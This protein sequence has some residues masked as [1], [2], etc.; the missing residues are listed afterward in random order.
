MISTHFTQPMD[1]DGNYIDGP[2]AGYKFKEELGYTTGRHTGVDYNGPGSGNA[3]LGMEIRSIGDGVVRYTGD[4]TSIGFGNTVIIEHQLSD[5]LK[6]E[7]GCDSLFSRYMHLNTIDVTAGDAVTIGQRIGSC[8]NTGTQWAHLH[9]DVYKSTIEGGGVHFRYDKNTQLM[10]YLDS[11]IFIESHNTPPELLST[12]GMLKTDGET[13]LRSEPRVAPETLSKWLPADYGYVDCTGFEWGEEIDGNTLWV[14]TISG[15]YIHSS[16]FSMLPTAFSFP[17]INITQSAIYPQ[18]TTDKFV[19]I[20][21]N[22][23]NPM[24]TP[25]PNVVIASN[26]QI[27]YSE[28]ADALRMMIDAAAQDKVI[29]NPQSGYRSFDTQKAIYES[30][31]AKDGKTKADTYSARPGYSEHQ[32]G[33]AMDFTPIEDSFKDTAAYMWLKNN[34]HKFGFVERF[35]LGKE[36]ITGYIYEPWHWRYVGVKDAEEI[37]KLSKTL[38]EYYNVKGG[39]YE[40]SYEVPDNQK[41]SDID[42]ENNSLLKQILAI[43]Q[44]L[45]N[46]FKSIFK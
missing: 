32:T 29:L 38:E 4:K 31:I 36:M 1:F 19:S 42:M 8:G 7:L 18:P 37:K 22:K 33:L 3:D 15:R 45:I 16:R 46:K 26:G 24:T 10:S 25:D 43:L 23:K 39:D 20:V 2:W 40:V 21:V 41:P 35:P 34:A 28:A 9:L 44:E 30:Y 14:K 13:G 17:K 11:Y 6:S 27:M 5:A 12:Q